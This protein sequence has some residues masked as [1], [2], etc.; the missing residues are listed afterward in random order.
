MLGTREGSILGVAVGVVVDIEGQNRPILR[1]RDS[2]DSLG[3]PISTVR[4]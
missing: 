3:A 1:R 2:L 4:R